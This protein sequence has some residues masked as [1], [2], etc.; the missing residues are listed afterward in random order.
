MRSPHVKAL[1]K[2]G[3]KPSCRKATSI[4]TLVEDFSAD[5]LVLDSYETVSV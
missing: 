5:I 4:I 3:I 2:P 1:S